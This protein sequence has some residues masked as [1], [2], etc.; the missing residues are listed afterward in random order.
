MHA[1]F[2]AVCAGA[3]FHRAAVLAANAEA[4]S[5]LRPWSYDSVVESVRDVVSKYRNLRVVVLSGEDGWAH[6]SEAARKEAELWKGKTGQTPPALFADGRIFIDASRI[7]PQD[8]PKVILHEAVAHYG[9]RSIIPARHLNGFLDEVYERHH[10]DEGFQAVALEYFPELARDVSGEDPDAP[11]E[12]RAEL[13]TPEERRLVAEEFLAHTAEGGIRPSWWKETMARIR[14]YL[15][16]L[17]PELRFSE[18]EIETA[19]AR[20]A[21]HLRRSRAER[22][23]GLRKSTVAEH[24]SASMPAASAQETGT[25]PPTAGAQGTGTVPPSA[26]AEGTGTASAPS[27]E[28]GS[29]TLQEADKPVPAPEGMSQEEARER[30]QNLERESSDVRA[31]FPYRSG[32]NARES[33]RALAGLPLTNR[34][35]NAQAQVNRAQREKI[36]SDA[37][38][39]KSAANGFAVRDH[40]AAAANIDALFENAVELENRPDEKNQK[41]NVRIHRYAAPIVIRG[42]LATALLTLKESTDKKDGTRLYSLELTEI[43]SHPVNLRGATNGSLSTDGMDKLLRKGEKVKS[44]LEKNP[45]ISDVVAAGAE[46][47]YF[48][49]LQSGPLRKR[50][51]DDPDGTE[52]IEG[53]AMLHDRRMERIVQMMRQL[54]RNVVE[55][56]GKDLAR[57]FAEM[58]KDIEI[59]P[60][61]ALTAARLARAENQKA[62]RIAF[63]QRRSK[64]LLENEGLW[65][66]AAEYAGGEDFLIRP[67]ER[68]EGEAFHGTWISPEF[69]RHSRV[70]ER[71][72][73]ESEE[74]YRKRMERR[75]KALKN[76]KGIRSDDL[77][78]AIARKTGED[79]AV[80]ERKLIEYFR[81]LN[82]PTL[83]K[84]YSDFLKEANSGKQEARLLADAQFF[85]QEENRVWDEAIETI[86]RGERVD[87][88]W[89][90]ENRAV[91]EKMHKLLFGETAEIPYLP[92]GKELEAFNE[93]IRKGMARAAGMMFRLFSLHYAIAMIL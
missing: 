57:R 86:R 68:Y 20:S 5:R 69:N 13:K 15:R 46:S 83:W 40:M 16:R 22:L 70:P 35:T 44:F 75:A 23:F 51:A 33:L 63:Q 72:E 65:R 30:L 56:D 74:A 41:K 53:R 19:L 25:I 64:W 17:F 26:G 78:L 81:N 90:A 50:G 88:E 14:G 34:D 36:V 31:A 47:G 45:K 93:A 7:E 60:E 27:A 62:G 42:E 67:S 82:K 84:K 38:V 66:E 10:E 29:V 92:Q 55:L 3:A 11:S 4:A 49:G 77:A 89:I 85:A 71:K 87:A 80:V 39:K 76:A 37:A 73:N 6:E 21:R 1:S 79:A 48:E 2:S 12:R 24:R 18:T 59:S 32:R 43:K 58:Y 9:I 91:Y 54:V 28:N 61:E 8:V 52:P